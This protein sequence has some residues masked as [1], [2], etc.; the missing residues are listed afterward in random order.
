MRE[1][2]KKV[3]VT[4]PT[5][6][7]AINIWWATIHSTFKLFG[8]YLNFRMP[9]QQTVEWK[10]VNVLIVDEV[11]ML[12]P[13]YVD[14][15]D[16]CLKRF[17][18]NDLPFWWLQVVFVGDPKQLPPVYS[19]QTE[20]DRIELEWLKSKYGEELTFD[21]ARAYK[22]FELLELDRIYRQNDPIL[23]DYI[24]SIRGWNFNTLKNF[25]QWMGDSSSVHIMPYNNMVDAHNEKE[26]NKVPGMPKTYTAI[27]SG[28]F[29]VKNSITPEFLRLKPGARIMVTKNLK[30]GLVN[31]DLGTVVKCNVDEVVIMSDRFKSEYEIRI[32]EWKEIQYVWHK[33]EILW[34][35]YQIPLKLSWAITCHKVQW[36]T[37]DSICVH[38]IKGMTKELLYVAVSRCSNYDNLFI[39]T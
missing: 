4:A 24:N 18:K 7:A 34:L 16:L 13:D 26:L 22:G 29:N 11:S 2:E 5:G 19:S 1:Q 17:L 14:Q 37:L 23:I 12:W 20:L 32:E 8:S 39:K 25:K 21:K 10:G 6:I 35:F 33:E 15:A 3:I 31:G 38:Y 30:C 36:L 9:W 28:K 27:V